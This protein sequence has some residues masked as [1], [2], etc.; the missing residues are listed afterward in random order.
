MLPDRP[1]VRGS[2]GEAMGALACAGALPSHVSATAVASSGPRFVT[3]IAKAYGI[4]PEEI[5]KCNRIDDLYQ[6]YQGRVLRVP[7]SK[8]NQ[9]GGRAPSSTKLP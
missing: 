6:L 9:S 5:Y 4:T 3:S 7:P 1:E 2:G 8:K